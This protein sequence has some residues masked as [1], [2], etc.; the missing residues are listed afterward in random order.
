M[1]FLVASQNY[2][3][4]FIYTPLTAVFVIILIFVKYNMECNY[5]CL[6]CNGRN[7]KYMVCLAIFGVNTGG[8]NAILSYMKLEL[9]KV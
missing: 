6:Q 4:K 9:K 3:A 7:V 8:V 5:R 1:N 2:T